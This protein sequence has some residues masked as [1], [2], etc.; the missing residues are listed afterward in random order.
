MM[1]NKKKRE[2]KG[3]QYMPIGLSFGM[4]IGALIDYKRT[5]KSDEE[6]DK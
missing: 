2:S 1:K 6:K 4:A 5:S 3:T